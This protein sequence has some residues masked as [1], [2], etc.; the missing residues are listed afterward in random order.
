MVSVLQLVL[1]SLLSNY[2]LIYVLI[3]ALLCKKNRVKIYFTSRLELSVP[4]TVYNTTVRPYKEY[5]TP[6]M[7]SKVTE[8]VTV[9]SFRL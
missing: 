2:I 5:L 4:D 7:V 8:I 3:Y 9:F 1:D 6:H